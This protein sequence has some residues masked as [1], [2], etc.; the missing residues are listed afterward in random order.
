MAKNRKKIIAILSALA[1][2]VTALPV[3]SHATDVESDNDA[4]AEE[5]TDTS[6]EASSEEKEE[7]TNQVK[8]DGEVVQDGAVGKVDKSKWVTLKDYKLVAE[9]ETYKMYLY[10]PRLSIMLQN[11]KTGKIM[12][13][14]LS[15]EKDDGNSNS[16]WN[17]YMKSGIVINA[18]KDAKNTYQVDLVNNQN[19]INVS[20]ESDGFTADIYFDEYQFGLSVNVKLD[21]ED[22]VVSVPDKSIKED[23]D[24]IYISTISLFPF[25]GYTF[26]DDEDGYMLIPDGNG[27]LINLDNK[28][29][30]YT[31]GFS[32]NIYGGDA[33]F[34]DSEV[35]TYLWD[36]IDMV[37]DANEVIAPIF[38]MAHTK[39]RMGYIAVVESGDKR[40]S[41]EA[42]PNGVMV[43]YNRCF[44][45]FKVRDI[46]VQP[47]NNSNSGT[48]TKA[49]DKRTHMDMSVRY[50][51]LSGDDANYSA[52]ATR[53]RNYLLDNGLITKK[54]DSYNT[55]VDFLG[56]DREEFL[57][58][59]KAVTMTT[60]ENISEIFGELKKNGVSSLISMYK[61]WQKG[62][63]YNVPI[64]KYKAD[65]HIGGTSKLTSLIKD[66]EK[67]NYHLYL[68]NDALRLNPSINKMT[69]DMI[70]QVN[71][72][73]FEEEE[74]KEVYDT[75]YYLTPSKANDDLKDFVESYTD[76]GVKNLAVAGISN[77]IFSY[78]LKGNY[79]TRCDSADANAKLIEDVAKDTNLVLEQPVAYLWKDTNA[80]LDMPLGS[81][82]YMFVDEEVP[83]LSMVLKGIIPMYS[84]YVNFEANKQ[85][86]L[87]QMVEA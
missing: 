74:K 36:K 3:I 19:T 52:M 48:V 51:M 10:E 12:E 46:Y 35:K 53:Y 15:D 56:T 81:S 65:R 73:T 67:D 28:E 59:T 77:T 49:E 80:F 16:V 71:K 44:A 70:K 41:I 33:G 83:F 78:S 42:H 43:N 85:E 79:Y 13:S 38:G 31:T 68:Y 60:T 75:F 54:D 26:L 37:R 84:D 72:R 47:L 25:M 34:D 55:R 57:I 29:G 24:G 87:L 23:A 45:K 61:G 86:F 21:G 22:V 7:E 32:Q 69:Y 66:S 76:D 4:T 64:T 39:Q 58:G 82:D 14:T 50:M 1:L 62:G 11:K 2:M 18:I 8:E 9:N 63:L 40:A 30:R 6:T 5:T 17:G 27:A 20:E